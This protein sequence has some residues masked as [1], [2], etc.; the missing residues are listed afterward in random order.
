MPVNLLDRGGPGEIPYGLYLGQKG[1]DAA[2]VDVVAKEVDGG[3][4][5]DALLQIDDEPVLGEVGE[6]CAEMLHVLGH[7]LARNCRTSSR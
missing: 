3:L 6:Q 5:K 1:D 7:V 4:P 2:V